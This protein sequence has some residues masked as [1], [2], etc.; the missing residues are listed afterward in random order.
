MIGYVAMLNPRQA[1][2][3][4]ECVSKLRGRGQL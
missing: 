1:A 2:P 4:R 3:L